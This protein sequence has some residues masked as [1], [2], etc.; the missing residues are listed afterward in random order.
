[1]KMASQRVDE[2][3]AN[4]LPKEILDKITNA[5]NNVRLVLHITIVRR[6]TFIKLMFKHREFMSGVICPIDPP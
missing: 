4:M 2:P 1:M 3:T 6:I 5:G